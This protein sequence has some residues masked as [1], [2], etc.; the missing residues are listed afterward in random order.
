MHNKIIIVYIGI[1]YIYR[2]MKNESSVSYLTY[3]VTFDS[4]MNI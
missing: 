3:A 2:V 1:I 4:S